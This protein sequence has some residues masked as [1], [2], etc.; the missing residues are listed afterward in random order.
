M[1]EGGG[2]MQRI[3]THQR[4]SL[5]LPVIMVGLVTSILLVSSSLFFL[6]YPFPSTDR[7][8][9]YTGEHPILF[10]GEIVGEAIVNNEEVYLPLS[11]IQEHIDES[12]TLDE[13]SNS[14]IL[15]TRS[16]VI[17]MPIMNVTS[18]RIL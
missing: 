9:Y 1:E 2:I 13:A 6:L 11:F 8:T 18:L 15:T 14:I 7:V 17:Q 16:K 4:K 12:I 10:Q 3:E 5:S